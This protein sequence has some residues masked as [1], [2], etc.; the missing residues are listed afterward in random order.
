MSISR[1]DLKARVL[2]ILN[3]S[4]TY[5]GAYTD[6]KMNDAIE[7]CMDFI[8]VDMAIENEG[9]NSAFYYAD[10][11]VGDRTVNIP[12]DFMLIN[13]VRYRVGDEYIPLRYDQ[14]RGAVLAAGDSGYTQYPSRYRVV[15]NQIYFNPALSTGGEE[16][17][18]IEYTRYPDEI[19]SDLEEIPT[20]FDNAMLHFMK[21]RAASYL[22]STVG[23][24][25]K[26][27]NGFEHQW[28]N[29]VIRIVA[30]RNNT[31]QFV[32]EFEG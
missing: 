20:H 8:S 7:D 3:R 28:Y 21:F 4:S 2:R 17:L 18:Q 6:D 5:K 24:F 10:T 9:W 19:F 23:K 22:A 25:N 27:W 30:K 1:A 16:Y 13:E 26:E 11:A 15:D 29:Q 31:E 32:R 14:D 12:D